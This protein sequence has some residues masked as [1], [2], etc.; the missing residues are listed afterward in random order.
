M[1][2]S[3]KTQTSQ[4]ARRSFHKYNKTM[5]S[6]GKANTISKSGTVLV[7]L[8]VVETLPGS[9]QLLPLRDSSEE[10]ALF[11]LISTMTVIK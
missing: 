4:A 7:P 6:T 10:D 8:R 3:N 5:Q 1:L 9:Q 2:L 11:P